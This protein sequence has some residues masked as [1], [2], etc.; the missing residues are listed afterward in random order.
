M[1][2]AVGSKNPVKVKATENVLKRIYKDLE[3]ISIDVDSQVPDQPFGIDQT[4]HG[5]VNRAKNAYSSGFNLSVGVES[6]LMETPHSLTGYMDLQWCAVF[7]GNRT[8]LG[9]SSGFEYPPCVIEKVLEGFE[10]GDVMDQVTGIS[11]LGEKW[12]AVSY[13]SKGLLNRTE[14]TEQC[15]LTAMIPRI[16]EEIY[17]QR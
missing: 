12:G 11:N 10:V 6:G 2:V 4:I 8:T 5:A 9:V 14:N 16:R 3:V 17:F 15:I 13:L 7:D 1:K